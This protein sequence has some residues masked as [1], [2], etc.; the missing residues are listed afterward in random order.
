M[1][2]ENNQLPEPWLAVG[3]DPLTGLPNMLAF[4]SELPGPIGRSGGVAV[5]FDISRLGRI[6]DE[7]GRGAGDQ[8][9]VAF[10]RSLACAASQV[11]SERVSLYRFGGDEF[12]AVI[13]GP[14]EDA[15][16]MVTAMCRDDSTPAFHYIVVPFSPEAGSSKE[17]FFEVWAPLQDGLQI[18]DGVQTDPMRKVGHRLVEQ[19][20]DTVEQLKVS[21]RMAYTDDISGLPNQRAARFLLSEHIRKRRGDDFRISLLFVD[22]D[23]LRKY[24]D[25]LGYGPGNEMIRRLGAVLSASTLPTEVVARWLSGDEFMIILPGHGKTRALERAQIICENVKEESANW[26][27]PVTVSIGVATFPDDAVDLETLLLRA[28]EANAKAKSLGKDRV[29]GV[30][31]TLPTR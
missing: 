5:G 21:R 26:I 8:A 15:C 31:T 19:V 25:N 23:N 12:C 6:N 4:I 18:Q 27:Y 2:D 28:E 11:G 20:K 14:K 3:E 29:C 13:R 9:L 1:R 7:Q 10:A 22:G 17:A 24:N 16:K 30:D